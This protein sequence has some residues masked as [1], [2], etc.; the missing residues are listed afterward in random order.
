MANHFWRARQ[1]APLDQI[2]SAAMTLHELLESF[3]KGISKTPLYLT[4]I[5]QFEKRAQIAVFVDYW[6]TC[7]GEQK[8]SEKLLKLNR[9]YHVD[10]AL[11]VTKDR[12]LMD[13]KAA[14]L[15]AFDEQEKNVRTSKS[16][17]KYGEKK[18]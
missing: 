13:G 3:A 18:V 14:K 10:V 4:L 7:N 6:A 9:Y 8:F 12:R 17:T 15:P 5:H 11:I 16:T 2:V 1:W